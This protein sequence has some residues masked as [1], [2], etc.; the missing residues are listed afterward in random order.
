MIFFVYGVVPGI[1]SWLHIVLVVMSVV[2]QLL[3][4]IIGRWSGHEQPSLP[5]HVTSIPWTHIPVSFA[6]AC[7]V[8][9]ISVVGTCA[10]VFL[11]C[12]KVWGCP[13]TEGAQ[14]AAEVS[15]KLQKL[16]LQEF[17]TREQLMDKTVPQLKEMINK[18]TDSTP[19]FTE[20]AEMVD[21]L[22]AAGGSSACTCA[23]CFEDYQAGDTM[24]VMP[25]LHRFHVSCIDQ[26]ILQQARRRPNSAQTVVAYECPLCHARL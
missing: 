4:F 17:C 2:T 24:R 11:L 8:S 22:L 19:A 21:A 26:W 7:L 15:T 25:C 18:V 3:P 1:P 14:R 13:D 12:K 20:K 9:A 23:I 5:E 10:S 6:S 16:P